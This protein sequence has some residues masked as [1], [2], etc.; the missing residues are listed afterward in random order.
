MNKDDETE[1]KN[2]VD[3]SEDTGQSTFSS[4][5]EEEDLEHQS[6]VQNLGQACGDQLLRITRGPLPK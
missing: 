2:G 6:E 4:D 5:I 1:Q 3:D